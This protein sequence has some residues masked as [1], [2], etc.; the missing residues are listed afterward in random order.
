MLLIKFLNY[1]TA[2]ASYSK[3]IMN[4]VIKFIDKTGSWMQEDLLSYEVGQTK[5]IKAESRS[6]H[7]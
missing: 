3:D 1:I 5:W 4:S 2:I 6:T 7:Q